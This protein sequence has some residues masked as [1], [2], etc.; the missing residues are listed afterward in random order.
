V[1]ST[2]V[3]WMHIVQTLAD[4]ADAVYATDRWCLSSTVEDARTGE[5]TQQQCNSGGDESQQS[6]H[7]C[8][9]TPTYMFVENTFYVDTREPDNAAFADKA[10]AEFARD[11][12]PPVLHIYRYI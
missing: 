10:L 6:A 2:C 7:V 4:F 3:L 1:S 9:R 11:V 8:V 5:E 12:T